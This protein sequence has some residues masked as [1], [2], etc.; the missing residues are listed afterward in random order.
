MVEE[1]M[2]TVTEWHDWNQALSGLDVRWVGIRCDV[3]AAT[4]RERQ[5]GDRYPGL[6]RGTSRAAHLNASYSVEVDTS[7][8]TAD[9]TAVTLFEHLGPWLTGSPS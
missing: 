6:A 9:E 8:A 2:I 7:S 4:A 1:V 3:D 5:R